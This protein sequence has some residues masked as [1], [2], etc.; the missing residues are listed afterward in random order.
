MDA[1][2]AESPQRVRAA[3]RRHGLVRRPLALRRYL[4]RQGL[5]FTDGNRVA[6]YVTGEAG[7]AAMLA[8]IESA[9]RRIHLETYILR[10]D[11]T[12]RRFLAALTRKARGGVAVRLIFD[13]VGSLRLDPA[14][15]DALREAGG[16]VLSFNPLRRFYPRWL[17]RRRDHRKILVVD[18]RVAFTGG[19]NIGDEYNLGPPAGA[20]SWRD[21]H[22]QVEGPAVQDLEAVFLESW[23]RAD[24]S[25][26]P[27]GQL[28]GAP[29]GVAGGD[30]VAVVADGPS[31][32]RRVV[33]DLV[34]LA[35]ATARH[36]VCLTSP[37]FAPDP[38]VLAAIEHTARRG[39]AI[40]LL[41]AGR[42]DHPLL[43]RATRNLIPRLLA[44]GVAVY[45]YD[46]SM[47]HAKTTVV[48]GVW[49]LAGTS[50]LD[51]QS[52]EHSY[53]V[54]L[55]VEGGALPGQLAAVHAADL[56]RATR[57]DAAHLAR[58]G[59]VERTLDR[60]AAAALW[61]V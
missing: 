4:R 34:L 17:P 20:A 23:F 61:F 51:R 5:R 13:A 42:T 44:A 48:D 3:L 12:G 33:R 52:F 46:H 9:T 56:Q 45:E 22:L 15:L 60:A 26:L 18:G 59:L 16:E 29:A 37:Y 43:R 35:L 30:R 41:V 25:E 36:T 57:V 8:A 47:L 6:L 40:S 10:G 2:A 27:W 53:E 38:R 19:L 50:N 54:N 1:D 24:G 14:E 55:V 58:R 7:L 31:Y 28:L 11:L 21:T 32:R 49:T 39:V